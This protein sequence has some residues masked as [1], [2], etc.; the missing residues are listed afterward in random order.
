MPHM[1]TD[2]QE[3]KKMYASRHSEEEGINPNYNIF[4]VNNNNINSNADDSYLNSDQ[5][6][7]QNDLYMQDSVTDKNVVHINSNKDQNISS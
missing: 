1:T 6:T 2:V 7:T 3:G 5:V 4:S